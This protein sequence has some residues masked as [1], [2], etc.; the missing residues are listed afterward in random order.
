MCVLFSHESVFV[1]FNVQTQPGTRREFRKTAPLNP[2]PQ[3]CFPSLLLICTYLDLFLQI[4]TQ[5]NL[6]V[7][8][9]VGGI[10]GH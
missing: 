1:Q 5:Q 6:G 7:D 2:S 10:K 8:E 4:V 9:V 3:R